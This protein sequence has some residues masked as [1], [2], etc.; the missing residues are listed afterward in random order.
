MK[1]NFKKKNTNKMY[2]SFIFRKFLQ[3]YFNQNVTFY[4]TK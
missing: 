2:F 1:Q 3:I 4:E